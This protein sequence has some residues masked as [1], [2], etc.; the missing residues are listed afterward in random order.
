MATTP[1]SDS[2]IQEGL[3][4]LRG[5]EREG[6]TLVKTFKLDSYMAGLAL[7]SAIGTIAEGL[8][9][10]PDLTIGY[11]K[12]RVVFTTHDAG[13]RIS[14]KDLDAALAIDALNYPRA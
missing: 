6:D 14:Q 12:V 7:A 4:R 5:W 1:L 8:N 10:H 11:K 9:H 13:N 3:A 2:D